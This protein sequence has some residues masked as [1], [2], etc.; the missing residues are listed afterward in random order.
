MLWQSMNKNVVYRLF[1]CDYTRKKIREIPYTNI[2]L[3]LTFN[4]YNKLQFEVQYNDENNEKDDRFDM[5]KPSSLIYLMVKDEKS[6]TTLYEE[7]FTIQNPNVEKDGFIITKQLDCV[8][9]HYLFFAK[10]HIPLFKEVSKLY[11]NTGHDGLINYMLSQIYNVYSVN[12]ISSSLLNKYR[13]FDYTS[14]N[15]WEIFLDL[16]EQFNC[17]IIFNNVNQTISIYDAEEYGEH[18]GLILNERNFIDKISDETK[19]ETIVTRLYVYGKDKNTTIASQ[20]ITGQEYID[21]LSYFIDNGLMPLSLS[22]K[23]QTYKSFVESQ[24]GQ[25][26]TYLGQ[27]NTLNSDLLTKNNEL[28]VLKQ[29]KASLE[30]QMD[31]II[32]QT[33]KNNTSYNTVYATYQTNL[34][35]ITTKEGQISSINQQIANVNADIAT[36]HNSISWDTYFTLSERKELMKYIYTEELTVDSIDNTQEA[37]LYDYAKQVL[38]RKCQA[39]IN[40]KIDSIDILSDNSLTYFHDRV[41]KVGDFITVDCPELKYNNVR[42]RLIEIYHNPV[43]NVLDFTFSNKDTL[44]T[45]LFD[46]GKIFAASNQS[47]TVLQSEKNNYGQYV[48]DKDNILMV[49]NMIDTSDNEIVAGN[50]VIN[51]RGFTGND[52]GTNGVLKYLD[53]KIVLSKDGMATYNTFISGN[54]MYL[55]NSQGTSRFILN[56]DTGW[57]I[58]QLVNGQWDS[59]IYINM[60]GEVIISGS[61]SDDVSLGAT[62]A[63]TGLDD[64]GSL[65]TKVLPSED[66]GTPTGNG[67]Y[68]GKDYLGYFA[69][70][71]WKSF[72]DN[73]GQFMFKGDEDNY[74]AWDGSEMT[75]RGKLVADDISSGILSGVN[76]ANPARTGWLNISQSGN[77]NVADFKFEVD[78]TNVPI[79]KIYNDINASI[80]SSFN[81]NRM[82]FSGASNETIIHGVW[83]CNPDSGNGFDNLKN[84]SG[85]YYVTATTLASQ[86]SNLQDQIDG[87][88]SQ[89]N[90]YH[91]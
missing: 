48:Q 24:Q 71:Q 61:S 51:Q 62:K 37:Q 72:I 36:L 18:T 5:I 28:A 33:Y 60:D 54:G 9:E 26:T 77:N 50:M 13:A 79:F 63:N 67:L 78:N 31:A 80:I 35:N 19:L 65:I 59:K 4:E 88:Q 22:A 56:I 20:N 86:I 75:V 40:L 30:A 83:K 89:I 46:L 38:A 44:Q 66:I 6:G 27:L 64:N 91:P 47:A 10:K 11:D 8:S 42:I 85:V 58:D 29:Q 53:D 17:F 55:E 57:Q 32:N 49:G 69:S 70:G 52:I 81:M 39:P 16:Y 34:A 45:D 21:D 41:L 2:S 14:K 3:T 82:T 1:L 90:M 76:F 74:V 7:Y 43:D 84:S 68:L 23:Y 87:L 12:Y 73:T 25:W 15:Y